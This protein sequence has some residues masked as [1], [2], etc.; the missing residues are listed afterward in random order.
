MPRDVRILSIF[1]AS[2]SDL[3]T[4]R[5]A[6]ESVIDEFNRG[7]LLK[8]PVRLE[9]LRWEDNAFPAA[10]LDGQ[11]TINQQIGDEYDLFIGLMWHRF[12]SPT[13]RAGSGT[14]EEF[15]HALARHNR[16]KSCQV[17]F[18]FKK[19]ASGEVKCAFIAATKHINGGD[20]IH[21]GLLMTFADFALFAIAQDSLNTG[22]GV[23]ISLN[24]EFVSAGKLDDFIEAK[25]RVVRSTRSL[26]FVDGEVVVGDETLLNFSGIIKK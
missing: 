25:G 14:E 9:L 8:G 3:A 24:G 23:T 20:T 10:G 13:P 11:D 7:P 5:A 6:F 17:M 1:L 21:G 15:R 18:Y 2:P 26:V 16:D 22:F 12:G 4:E 19:E